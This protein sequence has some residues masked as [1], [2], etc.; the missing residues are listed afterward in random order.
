MSG[1]EFLS[2]STLIALAL[3]TVAFLLTIIRIVRGPTLPD[4]VLALDLLV[5]IGIAY[6]AVGAIA[7]GYFLYLDIAISL[8]LVGFLATVAFARFI[9]HRGAV[10]KKNED[11]MLKEELAEKMKLEK[12]AEKEAQVRQRDINKNIPEKTSAKKTL[13][14]KM[15]AKKIPAKK[16]QVSRVGKKPPVG[17]RKKAKPIKQ[18][19]KS[20]K[21]GRA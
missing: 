9:L 17:G 15:P 13:A 3:L 10:N 14:K 20:N 16:T 4:R 19:S 7:T 18:A 6:I 12:L 8:G 2:F 5:A 1:A 21:G 11:L